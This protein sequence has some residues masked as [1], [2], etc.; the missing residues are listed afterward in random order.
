MKDVA[1]EAGV[2]VN[3]VSRVLAGK[4]DVS[5]ETRAKVLAVVERLGYKPN[6]LA[7]GL[8]S[9]RTGTI[10]VIVTDIANPF[11]GSVV[12]G[13]ERA[14]RGLDYSLILQ[15]TDENYELEK[16]A[17]ELMLAERVDGVLITPVQSGTESLKLLRKAGVPFVLLGRRFDDFPADWVV[18]DDVRGGSLAAEHLISLGHRR[19]GMISGPLRISSA[20]AR[21]EGFL[22]ALSS[23][24]IT[25]DD[26]LILSDAITVEDGYRLT[27]ELLEARRAPT[28]IFCYSDF[29]AFGAVAALRERGLRV[30]GDVAVVGYDDVPLSRYLEVPLTTV[31]IP[32]EELGKAALELLFHRLQRDQNREAPEGVEL[33]VEL[34]VRASTTAGP[35]GGKGGGTERK[36]HGRNGPGRA[37][38]SARKEGT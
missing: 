37:K 29:V 15:D 1:R 8:R 23:H 4:P 12:K 13:I 35:R 14:A 32:K 38:S 33:P 7:R 21:L 36:G 30:P 18:T 2:S 17:V 31:R 19:I 5:P 28:A 22:K 3:T 10:G 27:T 9:N 6:R 26:G 25:P 11:F 24:G 34:V 16:K 20:R